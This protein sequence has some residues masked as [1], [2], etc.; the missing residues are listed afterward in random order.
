MKEVLNHA[1]VGEQP[2]NAKEQALL[3]EVYMRLEIFEQGCR[4]YHEQA[5]MT[6][7]ILRLRDPEQDAGRQPGKEP[8][9]DK[10]TLQL[11]TLKSTFNNCVADQMQNM[12]E[13]R[14]L[15]ETPELQDAATDMQDLLRFVVYDVNHYERVHRRRAE[16]LYGPGTAVTQVAW[17]ETMDH[18]KGNIAII[19]WPIEAF[20]WDPQA[21]DIQDARALIK[22]SW[23]PMSWYDAHYPDVAPYIASEEGEHNSVGMPEPQAGRAGDD[24]D[25][26]MLLEYWYRTY[27][28][29]T[30]QYRINVAY[31]AGH[32][33]LEHQ[34]NVYA[35]GMYPFVLDVHSTIE[36]MPVGDGMVSEL[37]PM[38]RYINRYARYIDTN[39]RYSS[40]GRMLTRRESGID[41]K[42]LADWSVDMIEGDSIE[43]GRDWD[44]MQHQPF[45]GLALQ[46]LM[47]MQS[48]LKQDSGANQFTRGETTGG[49]VS[50]KGIMA[51]QEA[52]GKITGLRTDTL[53]AGFAEIVKQVLW[54][55][56]EFYEDDRVVAV[57]GRAG[58]RTRP[59]TIN[60][61]TLFGR[62]DGAVPP[63]PYLVQIEVNRRDP[64]YVE[65][66]NQ[67]FME[68]YT[69]AAQAKQ[70]F[71][72]SALFKVMNIEGK[73]RLLPIIEA[74][75]QHMQQMQQLQAQ[76]EQMMEQLATMQ[77]ENENLRVTANQMVNALANVGAQ[78][79][80]LTSTAPGGLP[81]GQKSGQAGLNPNAP[82]ALVNRARE[83]MAENAVR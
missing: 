35:H 72:L 77:K 67:R 24:E 37:V 26:A 27:D 51:L 62:E 41:R 12:P 81:A 11:Q 16:D 21:E 60:G 80:G 6:R 7:A 38:M 39:L 66:M 42:A 20:L 64:A 53:N 8:G 28:A 55:M 19:R 33:L 43:K 54:L 79:P 9:D 75:E 30:H 25:R 4:E 17:D 63:P 36:G 61:K 10:P 14:L 18:G 65:A 29:E 13:A 3:T 74:N 2:L 57:T 58:V 50:A 73:D 71:P 47:Q 40:K 70:Y 1:A 23:H 48:D 5:K 45:N 82:A 76:N 78:A 46:Q 69:M 44:W 49:V 59:V 68:A 34:E 32:A 22:V 56:A 31:C 15:P 52:G 83:S